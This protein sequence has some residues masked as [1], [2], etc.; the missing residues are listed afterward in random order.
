PSIARP[1]TLRSL[2]ENGIIRRTEPCPHPGRHA[3]MFVVRTLW[4]GLLAGFVAAPLAAQDPF[5]AHVR[6]TDPLSPEEQQKTFTLPPGFEIQLF[7]AEPDILK[8][9]N[10]AFDARGRLWISESTEYPYAAPLDRP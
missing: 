5:A 6:P 10:M 4:F 7:A 2:F 9:M 3:V 8:P 1:P